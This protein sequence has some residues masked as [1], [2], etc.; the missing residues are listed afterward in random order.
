MGGARKARK[1]LPEPERC[2]EHG[3]V[4]FRSRR[5]GQRSLKR[6][7]RRNPRGVVPVRVYWEKECGSYHVTSNPGRGFKASTT[8]SGPR[9]SRETKEARSQG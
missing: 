4:R 5:V 2:E 3:K 8:N 1:P 7:R 6:F 9:E